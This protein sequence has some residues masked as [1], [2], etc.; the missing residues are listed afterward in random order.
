MQGK[1]EAGQ[2]NFRDELH[3]HSSTS[4]NSKWDGKEVYLTFIIISGGMQWVSSSYNL[5]RISNSLQS[6]TNGWN[7]K[8]PYP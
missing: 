8:A 6:Q 5:E 1:L 2:A 3:N 4:G 7:V